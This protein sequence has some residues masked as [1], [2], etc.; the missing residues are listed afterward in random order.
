MFIIKIYY[1]LRNILEFK[2]SLYLTNTEKLIHAFISHRIDCSNILLS[3]L[4]DRLLSF[5]TVYHKETQAY[6]LDDSVTT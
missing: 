5:T 2:T 4:P 3:D 1:H 6:F